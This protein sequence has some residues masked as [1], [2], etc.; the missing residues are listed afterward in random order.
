MYLYADLLQFLLKI[1]E[2]Y[3]TESSVCEE[4]KNESAETQEEEETET[5]VQQI[6]EASTSG[7]DARK[8]QY[9]RRKAIKLTGRF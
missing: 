7:R 4:G 5:T 8:L 3:E 9:S 1:T 6:Y 2:K